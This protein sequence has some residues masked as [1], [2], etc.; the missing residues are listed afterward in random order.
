MVKIVEQV[1]RFWAKVD[2]SSDCWIWTGA[3]SQRGYG[4]FSVLSGSWV[5]AHRFSWQLHFGAIPVGLCVCHAC[6]NRT[7]VNPS[8]LWLGTHTANMKDKQVKG[9]AKT[10]I[11]KGS[12]RQTPWLVD[13]PR[14]NGAKWTKFGS[15]SSSTQEAS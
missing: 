9:R 6:D 10:G 2:K 7:C 1:S 11:L 14:I 13:I 5:L 12:H 4:E 8:H 15:K 3:L